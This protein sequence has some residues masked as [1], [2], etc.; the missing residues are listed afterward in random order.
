MSALAALEKTALSALH[1]P[2]LFREYAYADGRW[3]AAPDGA[4]IDVTNPADGTRV[5]A[6]PA[7]SAA[8]VDE[9]IS[10]AHRAFREWSMLL[11]QE[12]SQILLRWHGLIVNAR[13]DLARLDRKSTRLNSSH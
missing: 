1:D 5:G 11:P 13:E 4:E 6:V 9:T 8:Q 3:I 10:A 7:L 12:R 2:R